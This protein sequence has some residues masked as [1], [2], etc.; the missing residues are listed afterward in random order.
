MS[1]DTTQRVRI[2]LNTYNDE[3]LSIVLYQ[4][5]PEVAIV[6]SRGYVID[7]TVTMLSTASDLIDFLH[8]HV[9]V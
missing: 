1:E 7:D 6:D 9:R 8:E 4:G 2:K 3:M 5:R